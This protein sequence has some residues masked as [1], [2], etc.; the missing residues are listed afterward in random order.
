MKGRKIARRSGKHS[1]SFVWQKLEKCLA[2][3]FEGVQRGFLSE[4]LKEKLA[5]CT[6]AEDRNGGTSSVLAKGKDGATSSV[7]AKGKDGGTSSMLA[8]GKDGRAS[9]MLAKG[10]DGGASSMLAKGGREGRL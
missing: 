7:L 9:S 10:K 4:S 6:W 2:V 5:P 8:K 3:R 1:R